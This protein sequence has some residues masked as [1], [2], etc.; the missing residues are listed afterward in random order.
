MDEATFEPLLS[1]AFAELILASDQGTYPDCLPGEFQQV[2]SVAT[3]A[4]EGLL[5]PL[6][7]VVLRMKD[8]SIFQLA[9][10]RSR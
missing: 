4:Q 5:T 9:V 6:K 8:G 3:F 7:G 1:V 10:K 2:K